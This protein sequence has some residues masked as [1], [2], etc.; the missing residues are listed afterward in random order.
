MVLNKSDTREDDVVFCG[1]A[2][3]LQRIPLLISSINK[4][5]ERGGKLRF[6]FIGAG[7]YSSAIED[8]A[9]KFSNVKYLGYQSAP[10]AAD[11]VK[12]HRWA[13]LPIDDEVTKYAF[14][15]KS[16]S[17]VLS[18]CQILAIC[19]LSTSVERW[20]EKN[21]VGR[22]CEPEEDTLVESFKSME[23]EVYEFIS[24]AVELTERL[25]ISY[26]VQQLMILCSVKDSECQSV[27]KY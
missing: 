6:T 13:L 18:G 20:I 2:G 22:V 4:Y 7:I 21:A 10:I 16:S 9:N 26:F 15:S 5:L 11:I 25:R 14:P 1:N 23:N 19:G 8:L 17:Y 27:I 3:R 24:P 12:N